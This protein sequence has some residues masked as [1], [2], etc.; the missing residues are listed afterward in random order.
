MKNNITKPTVI[1]NSPWGCVTDKQHSVQQQT[2]TS[3]TLLTL[4]R[5]CWRNI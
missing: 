3:L 5:C 4:Y 1:Y 2:Q